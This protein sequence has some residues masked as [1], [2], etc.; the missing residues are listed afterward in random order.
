MR[1]VPRLALLTLLIP[2]TALAKGPVV[3][4]AETAA[5]SLSHVVA[6]LFGF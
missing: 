1:L 5:R 4:V 3:S 2:G 6:W